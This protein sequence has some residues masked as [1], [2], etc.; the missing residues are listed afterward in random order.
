MI[1]LSDCELRAE[2]IT[3]MHRDASAFCTPDRGVI[4]YEIAALVAE[5]RRLDAK[6]AEDQARNRAETGAARRARVEAY[7][8]GNR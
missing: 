4:D 7:Y 3:R 8:R 5:N 1:S 2:A 6:L